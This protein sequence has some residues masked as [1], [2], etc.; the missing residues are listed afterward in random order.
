[1][2]I[3]ETEDHKKIDAHSAALIGKSQK[4]ICPCCQTELVLKSGDIKQ[5]HFAHKSL[6]DCDSFTNDM[7][8]W[9]RQW[10]EQFPVENREVPMN[11]KITRLDFFHAQNVNDFEYTSGYERS[12]EFEDLVGGKGEEIIEITHRADVCINGYVIEF[13]HSPLSYKEFNERNW[14]YNKCGYKVIWIFDM[15]EKYIECTGQAP[16]S[17]GYKYKWK[18]PIHTLRDWDYEDHNVIILFQFGPMTG[19][20]EIERVTWA[21]REED[22]DYGCDLTNMKRFIT[23][24]RPGNQKTFL[25]QVKYHC[26]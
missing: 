20:Q 14:F 22:P 2:Y 7:S 1:M 21:I 23:N 19:N 3:A 5:A 25:N 4:Y 16:Y 9:H 18:N 6:I 17:S 15:S 26:F 11:I 24:G 12:D 13:Q 8:V 10:Q